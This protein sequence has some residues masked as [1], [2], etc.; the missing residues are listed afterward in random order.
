MKPSL[1]IHVCCAPDEAY[2]VQLM[3]ESRELHCYFCNPNIAPPEEYDLR[4]SEAKRVAELYGVPF[5]ADGYTPGAWE[6]AVAGAEK[7]PEGGERCRRCFMLRLRRTAAFCR[8]TSRPSFATVM[9]ISPHK[10]VRLLDECGMIA[11]REAGVE[12]EPFDF[13]KKDGFRKSTV[14]SRELGLY[15]QDYCGCRLSRDERDARKRQATNS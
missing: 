5:T 1:V 8:A 3:K 13:K 6:Q 2:V 4:L 11:A 10:S 7:T 15:R 9:S 12:Y 14:L